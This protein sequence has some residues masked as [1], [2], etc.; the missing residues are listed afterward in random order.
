MAQQTNRVPLGRAIKFSDTQLD[1]LSTI[2]PDKLPIIQERA[3]LLWKRYAPAEFKTLLDA[4]PIG[5]E[6]DSDFAWDTNARKYVDK[7]T[8]RVISPKEIRAV[9]DDV[10]MKMKG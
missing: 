2:T 3:G 10:L 5:E 8:R 9:L 7:A 4:K 6:S 1:Q